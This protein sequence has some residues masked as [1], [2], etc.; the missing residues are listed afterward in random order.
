MSPAISTMSTGINI[1]RLPP[2]L[3]EIIWQFAAIQNGPLEFTH[4]EIG[5]PH[6]LWHLVHNDSG[7][8]CL[9]LTSVCRETRKACLPAI[10]ANNTFML[11]DVHPI[12]TT[13]ALDTLA[14]QLGEALVRQIRD[15]VIL[16]KPFD[17]SPG[18]GDVEL[19]FSLKSP[20][21]AARKF[22]HVEPQCRLRLR[23]EV[24][25]TLPDLN[26]DR[27]PPRLEAAETLPLEFDLNDWEGSWRA[28]FVQV[29]GL[30]SV[31]SDIDYI[32]EQLRQCRLDVDERFDWWLAFDG[33]DVHRSFWTSR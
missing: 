32:E 21:K 23:R 4:D 26:I 6:Q 31:R 30:R 29:G 20:L 5:R 10:Y 12:V 27:E 3:R 19:G 8:H 28:V 33:D 2:E 24:L 15:I 13:D 14:Y 18:I 11:H 7:K 16:I 22:H 17:L 25:G 9:A 1:F